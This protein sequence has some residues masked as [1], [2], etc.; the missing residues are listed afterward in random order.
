MQPASAPS[1][2]VASERIR[3]LPG[4]VVTERELTVPLDHAEPGG[5]RI[6]VFARELAGDAGRARPALL[7]LNGGPGVEAP[8]PLSRPLLPGWLERAL[9]DFRVVL[10][11]QRG[12]G[13]STPLGPPAAGTTPRAQAERLR[14]FRADAIVRDA[15]CVRAALGVERW[16]VLGHSYG[17][18]CALTYLS[19]APERLERVLV[20]GGLPPLGARIDEVYAATYA[21]VL[22]RS[23]AYYERYPEDRARVLDLHR[24]AD[25]GELR[26][27]NGDR[28]TSRRIRQLGTL[29]GRSSGAERLHHLL[30]LEPDSPAFAHDAAAALRLGRNPLYAVLH[31]AAWADGG[32]TRWAARRL[33]PSDYD[34]APELF[35]GEHVF[36]WTF[37]DDGELAPLRE[38]AELLAEQE[39]PALYD[40]ARL[41]ANEVPVAAAIHADD[42]YVDA[43]L[44]RETAARVGGL[45]AWLDDEHEHDGLLVDGAAVLERLLGLAGA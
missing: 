40:A 1:A 45:R 7:F 10:L 28:L 44:A 30:E 37:E 18:F 16:S 13:R 36:P 9:R 33:L 32:A 24:R 35:A 14:R 39:W 8:R 23:R 15:E 38:A 20:A 21:H 11:D 34:E 43:G 31:E 26:L 19:L 5:E 6:R 12:T 4:L 22:A 3:R 25:A 17:G 2:A 29:L 42:M 27:P 41:A